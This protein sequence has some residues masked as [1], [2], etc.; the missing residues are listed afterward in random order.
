MVA[1]GPLEWCGLSL[2]MM[3]GANVVG[4]ITL[5][6]CTKLSSGYK[7]TLFS[8]RFSGADGKSAVQRSE[9]LQLL[10]SESWGYN[11]SCEIIFI[12]YV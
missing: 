5:S 1:A 11:V 6:S 10:L 8:V 9:I 7:T 12:N 4:N 2:C 3:G